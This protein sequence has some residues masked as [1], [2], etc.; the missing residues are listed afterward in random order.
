MDGVLGVRSM[1]R[2]PWLAE[3]LTILSPGVYSTSPY[4]LLH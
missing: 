2:G 3:R 1:G 4:K